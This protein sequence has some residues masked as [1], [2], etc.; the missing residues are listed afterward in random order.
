SPVLSI[1]FG[2]GMLSWLS[3]LLMVYVS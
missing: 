3:S 1:I 2:L